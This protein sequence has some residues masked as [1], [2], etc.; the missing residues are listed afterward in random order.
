MEI[1][2]LKSEPKDKVDLHI[3]LIAED[4]AAQLTKELE[5]RELSK[6]LKKRITDKLKD[7]K[8]IKKR[9]FYKTLSFEQDSGAKIIILV[10]KK[11]IKTFELQIA[12]RKSLQ[13][14]LK[15]SKVIALK[16]KHLSKQNQLA[17]LSNIA[18]MSKTAD[19][20]NPTYG[21]KAKEDAAD[22]KKE[23]GSRKLHIDSELKDNELADAKLKNV[24]LAEA[25]N[26][27]RTLASLPANYLTSALYHQILQERAYKNKYILRFF[28]K[29]K[30]EKMN[31]GAFS[32]VLRA[33]EKSAGGLAHLSY[34]SKQKSLGKICLVGK[35]LCFDT[36]GYNI[37]TGSYMY[38]MHRDMTGSAVALALFEAI[39]KL[40]LPY[41]VHCVMAIAENYISPTAFKPNEVVTAMNGTSIEVVDTDAEGRMV[42]SDALCFA[43]ELEPDLIIDYATLTG[44]A[45]RSVGTTRSAVFSNNKKLLNMAHDAGEATGE[46]VWGFPIGEEYRDLLKSDYADIKQCT[47]EPGP[48]HICAATFLSEFVDEKIP[49][50][51]VDLSS[52]E[53][54]GGLGIIS[55]PVTGFGV[56]LGME[57]IE[58]FISNHP[59]DAK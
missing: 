22:K 30:L 33:D 57:V 28:D 35:G 45:V 23:K 14:V 29:A 25:N 11:S 8:D 13:E 5:H 26:L 53:N 54:S 15:E 19:W 50:L 42:L 12:L 36:G 31:A 21:K 7:V 38:S 44:A 39:I 55:T 40:Q 58:K 41:E 4:Q 18:Y 52:E 1:E 48:D 46:R 59:K 24:A 49:W 17:A 2:I 27:V 51:H 32:A 43:S 3:D 10:L 47:L 16:I 37:K 6:E 20:K 34:K 9:E 56:K